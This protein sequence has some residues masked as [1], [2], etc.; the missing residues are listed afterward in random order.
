[1]RIDGQELALKVAPSPT[2]A[3]Q[4]ILER[5]RLLDGMCVQQIMDALIGSDKRHTVEDLESFLGQAAGG[6]KMYDSQS[7]LV[8]EL[9]AQAGRKVARGRAGPLF[10]QIPGAQ[11]QVFWGQQP[12]ADEIPSDLI[13]QQLADAAFDAELVELFAPVFSQ[14]AKGLQLQGWRVELIEFFFG[15]RT[16][17]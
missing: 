4:R 15:V 17:R 12:K 5:L 16:G 14:G 8:H 13:R 3:T 10:Q 1:M 11:T 6:T 2:H 9:H 7:G